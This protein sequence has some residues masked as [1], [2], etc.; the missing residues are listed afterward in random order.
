[1]VVSEQSE[2]AEI[3][4]LLRQKHMVVFF[5]PTRKPETHEKAILIASEPKL[6]VFLG[7]KHTFLLPFC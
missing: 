7:L 6:V 1:M 4:A 2:Q 3:F 5:I